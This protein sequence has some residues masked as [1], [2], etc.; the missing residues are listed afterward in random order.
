MRVTKVAILLAFLSSMA[1]PARAAQPAP[2][3]MRLVREAIDATNTGDVGSVAQTYSKD[4]VLVDEDA[5]FVWSGPH[6]S[7]D[8]LA[9]VAKAIVDGKLEHFHGT[10][11]HAT[12]Y[13][14]SPTR[15]Y[16]VFPVVYT[17]S[18]GSKI[19]RETGTFTFV[20]ARRNGSWRIV[21]QTWATR[22]IV[23]VIREARDSSGRVD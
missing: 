21:S 9:A 17:G 11:E 23:V 13:D 14:V 12:A 5:P 4:A 22:A 10:M 18:V 16:A 6:A 8:W 19:S 15:A 2:E 20:F 1:V 7:R 3:L